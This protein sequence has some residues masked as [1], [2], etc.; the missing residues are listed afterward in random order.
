MTT[1]DH[2][3]HL[4]HA[5]AC[6]AILHATQAACDRL[7]PEQA[8]EVNRRIADGSAKVALHVTNDGQQVHVELALVPADCQPV[9]DKALLRLD[10]P[11]AVVAA[12]ADSVSLVNR[13]AMN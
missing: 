13:N 2:D 9:F 5:R 1:T 3:L 4:T 11:I 10:A 6:L 7:T 12:P 8:A